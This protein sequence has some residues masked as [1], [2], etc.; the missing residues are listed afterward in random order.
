M[1]ICYN[2]F[3]FKKKYE[4]KVKLKDRKVDSFIINVEFWN[5]YIKKK[6]MI[7]KRVG[8]NNIICIFFEFYWE[9]K[10]DIFKKNENKKW[11]IY[12]VV[13]VVIGWFWVVYV[14]ICLGNFIVV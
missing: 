12:Y 5:V 6:V 2:F 1:C 13:G 7:F 8:L 14:V 11:E 10:W 9:I 4:K 3:C